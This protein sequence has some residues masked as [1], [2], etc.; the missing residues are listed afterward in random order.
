MPRHLDARVHANAQPRE[1]R[2]ALRLARRQ[3]FIQPR[4]ACVI[5]GGVPVAHVDQLRPAR[6]LQQVGEQVELVARALPRLSIDVDE[7]VAEWME[8]NKSVWRSWLP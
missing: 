5:G 2:V 6:R 4:Q 8:A 3:Q 7:V 1:Q